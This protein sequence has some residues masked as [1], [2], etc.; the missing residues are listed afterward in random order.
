[1]HRP[2]R[3]IAPPQ[4]RDRPAYARALALVHQRHAGQLDP[5]G[6][7][8]P[9]HFERVAARLVRL[10]PAAT[11]AQLQA[12][13]LHDVFEPGG[14]ERQHLLNAGIAH[15]ALRIVER[16][17]L[18]GDGSDYL[19]YACGLAMGGDIAAIQVK[20]ADN[21]DA[22]DLLLANGGPAARKLLQTCYWPSSAVLLNALAHP[23]ALFTD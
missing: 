20:L 17:T 21:L 18:P 13:L 4:V 6:L 7:P 3:S 12:A 9:E 8:K 22:V 10:F 1:M 14:L 16:I 23:L 2:D 19:E 11:D 5:A 15:E